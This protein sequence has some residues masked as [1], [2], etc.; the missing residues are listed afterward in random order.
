MQKDRSKPPFD[1]TA[2]PES[3]TPDHEN[4][5][6]FFQCKTCV[7]P[8]GDFIVGI[9]RPSFNVEILRKNDF[10]DTL[11][12][13]PDGTEIKNHINFPDKK[14]E[15][16]GADVIYE[17]P[18]QFPFR[19]TTYI[20][21]RWADSVALRPE[22]I[23]LPPRPLVSMQDVITKWKNQ[24]CNKTSGS[25]S[26]K[27][28]KEIKEITRQF[29][30]LLPRPLLLALAESSTDPDDL[31][32]IAE[33][34]CTFI[35][36][37]SSIDGYSSTTRDISDHE[38]SDHEE[39]QKVFYGKNQNPLNRERPEPVGL[40]FK[41]DKNGHCQLD[42][43][44]HDLFE[45]IANNPYLP[46]S[47]KRAMVLVPGIQGNS[48]ITGEWQ[49]KEEKSHVFEYLRRNSYIPWG[50][51]AANMA[52]DAIRYRT[53][54]LTSEDISGMRHLYYQRTYIR[55]AEELNIQDALS[56][57]DIQ[58][59]YKQISQEALENLRCKIL[60]QLEKNI[61][62]DTHENNRFGE[63]PEYGI[64]PEEKKELRKKELTFNSS[65][66]GWNFGFGYAQSGYR[67]HASHQQIHQQYAMVPSNVQK[68]NLHK[69]DHNHQETLFPS[70]SCGDLVSDFVRRFREI[71]GK[72]FFECYLKAIRS[73][74]RTDGKSSLPSELAI[75]EDEKVI[76]FVPKAQ[77][78]Q[79]ELQLMPVIPCGNILEADTSMR[80]AIDRAILMAVQLLEKMGARMV[81]TIEYAGR[82]D[83]REKDQRI[84]YSFLPKIPHSPGAFSEAQLR[85]ING[86]YPEDFAWLCRQNL[87]ILT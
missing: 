54:D 19:G 45:I 17:I 8:N 80:Y 74:Q 38:I 55:L 70:Y 34:C 60:V 27:S 52:D 40:C 68:M 32:A 15:E 39:T 77:T 46:D 26:D 1:F 47:Y 23:C 67:L 71:N 41:K 3:V 2:I 58:G 5:E 14:V 36:G 24:N 79:W 63:S 43:T 62:S 37:Y 16:Q 86:H 49:K 4:H 10:I 87:K 13:L 28:Q 65:L 78:S 61:Q 51:F 29:I 11:G 30:E 42:I 84:L 20:N 31:I 53:N 69:R 83:S 85:W 59:R 22:K 50:H 48:E 25:T 81:T 72:N 21:S 12:T 18:N 73:N 9:H 57:S 76:L 75:H 44:D 66:W 6:N 64:H 56:A 35:Y 7:S 33:T 82:F